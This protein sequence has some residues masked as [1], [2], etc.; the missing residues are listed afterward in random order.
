MLKD[1]IHGVQE[2]DM[3]TR[4]YGSS[5]YPTSTNTTAKQVNTTF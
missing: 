5:K 2:T 4:F 3:S 1:R